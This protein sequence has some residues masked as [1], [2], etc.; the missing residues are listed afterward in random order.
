MYSG[1]CV[2]WLLEDVF[3]Q[4]KVLDQENDRQQGRGI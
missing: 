4:N 1:G 3:H 2:S